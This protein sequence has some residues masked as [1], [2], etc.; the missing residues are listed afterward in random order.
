MSLL[1][2]RD[3]ARDRSAAK[4]R[5]KVRPTARKVPGDAETDKF[6]ID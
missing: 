3:E 4:A 1:R 5:D 2:V 6:R